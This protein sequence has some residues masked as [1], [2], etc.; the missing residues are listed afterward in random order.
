MRLG[1]V[2]WEGRLRGW[3]FDEPKDLD[4]LGSVVISVAS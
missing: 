4:F 3:G 1:W 2:D